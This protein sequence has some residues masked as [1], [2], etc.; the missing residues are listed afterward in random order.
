MKTSVFLECGRGGR[1]GRAD[2]EEEQYINHA[3]IFIDGSKIL[4]DDLWMT[5]RIFAIFITPTE[6]NI[7][8]L[9]IGLFFVEESSRVCSYS[10]ETITRLQW[11]G[12]VKVI[13]EFLHFR[14]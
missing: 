1:D 4:G 9:L 2:E 13:K 10:K 6:V 7:L 12:Y 14:V 8:D 3:K 11:F 5:K